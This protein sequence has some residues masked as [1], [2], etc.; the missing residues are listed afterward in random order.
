MKLP[1]A[2]RPWLLPIAA[3]LVLLAAVALWNHQH[4]QLIDARRAAEA[5]QLQL[6]GQIVTAQESAGALKADV[7]KLL[8]ENAGLRSAY[9]AA[10]A[11]APG[12][13]PIHAGR[14]STGAVEVAEAPRAAE[15]PAPA[16]EAEGASTAAGPVGGAGQAACVL[17]AGDAASIE[18]QEVTLQ[19]KQGNILVVGTAAAWRESAPRARLFGGKF[20]STASS[21]SGLVPASPPRWGAGVGGLCMAAG[22]AA[23]PVLALPPWRILGFQVE[24]TLGVL[25]GGPGAGLTGSG[26]VRW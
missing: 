2:L 15:P 18:V 23:G 4:Q 19:T 20:Q 25:V 26:V 24:T 14:L 11:A 5:A 10:R 12:A 21:A 7:A 13:Q 17:A 16:A 1:D 22:C 9:D 6:R 3:L 8:S